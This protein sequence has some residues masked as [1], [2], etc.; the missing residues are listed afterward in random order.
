MFNFDS[1]APLED[2]IQ[3]YLTSIRPNPFASQVSM[4]ELY[5][6]MN[7]ALHRLDAMSTDSS[8]Y[9]RSRNI[10]VATFNK[11]IGDLKKVGIVAQNRGGEV[12]LS[13]A[14]WQLYRDK[15]LEK[16]QKAKSFWGATATTPTTDASAEV[17]S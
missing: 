4:F 15:E 13:E 16:T 12:Y 2:N 5:T 3:S 9:Y 7:E 1:Q 10:L 14:A 6:E 17:K 8:R 11:T